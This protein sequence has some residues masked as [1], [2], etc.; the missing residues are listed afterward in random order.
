MDTRTDTIRRHVD[1][2]ISFSIETLPSLRLAS[3]LY[4]YDVPFESRELR[5]ESVRYSLMALLGM[6]RAR[7]AGLE[8]IPDLDELW[9]RCLERRASFTPGDVGL[10]I[11]ADSRRDGASTEGLVAQLETALSDV[12]L[13]SLVGMEIAWIIIGLTHAEQPTAASSKLL[14]RVADHLQ[15]ERRSPSGLYY[16]DATSRFRRHLPNFATEI[17]TLMALTAL[18]RGDH[19][20][21]ARASAETLA[22]H[23]VRLRLPDGGWPWLYDADRADVA[24]AYEI[25]TVHQDA[26]APMGL[27]ELTTL[28][29]DDRWARAAVESVAWSRGSNELGVDLLDAEH[30]FAHRSIRRKAPWDRVALAANS[31][32]TRFGG[33][34]LL[35]RSSRVEVNRTCRPYHLGWMLEAWAGR[36]DPG[37]W[38]A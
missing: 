25:Y 12:V 28:T 38:T 27:L 8:G 19:L 1:E 30:G 6:Q 5:G 20:A 14:D 17:Y 23:L 10:A 24:E 3:G 16:H 11:W 36:S 31:A 2:L 21:G 37:G 29:G 15:R 34:R 9:S 4:C 35:A 32:S 33:K 22:E 7:A 13:A 18:A 26:M